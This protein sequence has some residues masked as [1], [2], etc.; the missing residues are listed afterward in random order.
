MGAQYFGLINL[1]AYRNI[2][3]QRGVSVAHTYTHGQCLTVAT[4]TEMVLYQTEL[5]EDCES[6]Q[7]DFH[8]QIYGS[9]LL[10][11]QCCMHV[12]VKI[13]CT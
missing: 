9:A 4:T 6:F 7:S 10:S 13:S 11:I 5:R 1:G 2:K 3:A 12:G 8:L